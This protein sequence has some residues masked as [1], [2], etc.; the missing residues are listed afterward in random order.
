MAEKENPKASLKRGGAP[1]PDMLWY[2]E[3][4]MDI[5]NW[6][7]KDLIRGFEI[8]NAEFD[9]VDDDLI[10]FLRAENLFKL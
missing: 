3:N 9:S 2:E 8:T 6:P 1:A 10:E 7:K 4:M 5:S